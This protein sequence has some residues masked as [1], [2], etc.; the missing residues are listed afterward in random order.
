MNP[1]G[2]AYESCPSPRYRWFTR[3]GRVPL[4][5]KSNKPTKRVG[6]SPAPLEIALSPANYVLAS[7]HGVHARAPAGAASA[8]ANAISDVPPAARWNLRAPPELT[9]RTFT[10]PNDARGRR[11][12]HEP[13][14]VVWDPKLERYSSV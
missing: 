6:Y 1:L 11:S 4:W 13:R 7:A 5:P 10:L 9:R 14:G 12:I 8:G 3:V 2:A